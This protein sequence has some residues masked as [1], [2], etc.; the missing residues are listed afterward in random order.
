[1]GGSV[2]L[3]PSLLFLTLYRRLKGYIGRPSPGSVVQTV[4]ALIN[5]HRPAHWLLLADIRAVIKT[6]ISN[7]FEFKMKMHIRM[8]N[9]AFKF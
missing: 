4:P 2:H 1:M 6:H 5:K 9:V 8:Q 7:I 3:F